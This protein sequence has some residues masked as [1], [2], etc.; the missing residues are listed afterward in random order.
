LLA[1]VKANIRGLAVDAALDLEKGIDPPYGYERPIGN[2]L[3][4]FSR[5]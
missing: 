4:E 3:R 1:D 2:A 5:L